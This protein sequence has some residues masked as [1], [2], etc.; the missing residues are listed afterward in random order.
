MLK[1][2]TFKATSQ[3]LKN[4]QIIYQYMNEIMNL[5][6]DMEN[7][8]NTEDDVMFGK[9]LDRRGDFMVEVDILKQENKKIINRFPNDLKEKMLS[10]IEPK[11]NVATIKLDNPL[12]TNLYDTNKRIMTLLKRIINL[13]K[14]IQKRIKGGVSRQA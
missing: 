5:T 14:S 7:A 1:L 13:D 10:I 9:F 8:M 2:N 4:L 3:I 11:N 6:K 12:E